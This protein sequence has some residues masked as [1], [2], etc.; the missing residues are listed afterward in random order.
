MN[1]T[2]NRRRLRIVVVE[3]N[4]DANAGLARLLE[5]AGFSVAGRAYDGLAGLQAVKDAQPDVAILD[6]AMP[7]LDGYELASR[8]RNELPAP[9]HLVAVSGFGA[10]SESEAAARKAGFEAYFRKP[11]SFS[12]LESLLLKYL[13]E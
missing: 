12:E 11:A 7:A 3:D 6:I 9:P 10:E 8:I 4:Y 13:T 1:A 5:K 2:S